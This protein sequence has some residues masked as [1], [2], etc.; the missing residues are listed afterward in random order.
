M[1]KLYIYYVI[2]FKTKEV[3]IIIKLINWCLLNDKKIVKNFENV[4]CEFNNKIL[5]FKEDDKTFNKVD[6]NNNKYTRETAEFIFQIDFNK[7]ECHYNLK[8]LN[9]NFSMSIDSE[10]IKKNNKI[11]LKYS[12]DDEEKQIIIQML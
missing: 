7:K 11:I 9:K 5:E 3:I 2:F 6:L 10:I 12:L 4:E 8:E 1:L